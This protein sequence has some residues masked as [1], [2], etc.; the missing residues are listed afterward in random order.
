[1]SV[2]LDL[3]PLLFGLLLS[4]FL[5]TVLGNLLIILAISSDSH[6]HTPMYFLL[7][8]LSLTDVEFISIT[9]PNLL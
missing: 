4:L 7:S 2:D 3:Q 6:L 5:V 1:L 8:S 9:V